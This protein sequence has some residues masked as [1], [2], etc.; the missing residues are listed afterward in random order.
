MGS[1]LLPKTSL[2]YCRVCVCAWVDSPDEQHVAA[3][4][5]QKCA[6]EIQYFHHRSMKNK[7]ICTVLSAQEEKSFIWV[8]NVC[9]TLFFFASLALCKCV[10][11]E[12]QR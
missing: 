2:I 5:G 7:Q 10:S 6:V 11:Y 3:S 4:A 1:V 12:E 8:E 9:D